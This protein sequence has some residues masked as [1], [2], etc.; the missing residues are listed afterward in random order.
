MNPW[1]VSTLYLEQDKGSGLAA[2]CK[3]LCQ[4]VLPARA[5]FKFFSLRL[6]PSGSDYRFTPTDSGWCDPFDIDVK[7]IYRV[8]LRL[9]LET[10]LKLDGKLE[11]SAQVKSLPESHPA[12]VVEK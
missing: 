9:Q 6:L 3:I 10:M 1:I 5:N 11:L 8:I 2:I 12:N 7:D 4:D